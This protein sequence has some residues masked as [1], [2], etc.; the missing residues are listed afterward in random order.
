MSMSVFFWIL[1]FVTS[2]CFYKIIDNRKLQA[3]KQGKCIVYISC[4]FKSSLSSI[5]R[6]VRMYV[7]S[8]R[9]NCFKASPLYSR[10]LNVPTA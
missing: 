6:F 1:I 10:V 3:R 7:L 2:L 8:I 5:K 9:T 4:I